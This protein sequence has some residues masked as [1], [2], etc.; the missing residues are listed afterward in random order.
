MRNI[1]ATVAST[2]KIVLPIIIRTNLNLWNTYASIDSRFLFRAMIKSG[3]WSYSSRVVD[4]CRPVLQSARGEWHLLP[5]C[6]KWYVQ[7]CDTIYEELS[8][9]YISSTLGA[10]NRTVIRTRIRHWFMLKQHSN[11]ERA[12]VKSLI[13]AKSH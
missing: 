8:D 4:R 2:M 7:I 10:D 5:K 3:C 9:L 1:N 13:D 11:P 12:T 6:V